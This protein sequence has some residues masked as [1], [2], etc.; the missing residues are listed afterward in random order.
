MIY[1]RFILNKVCQDNNVDQEKKY[2]ALTVENICT[3]AF[4]NI[5]IVQQQR[6]HRV[7]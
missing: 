7:L 1:D 3:W 6:F 4:G 5:R 2:L